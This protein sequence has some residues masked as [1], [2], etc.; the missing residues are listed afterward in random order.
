MSVNIT[1]LDLYQKKKKKKFHCVHIIRYGI[2][3]FFYFVVTI[4]IL[5][6]H[7]SEPNT[8]I[9]NK[10]L[11]NDLATGISFFLSVCLNSKET[12]LYWLSVILYCILK[13]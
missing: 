7:H 3:L 1:K 12:L 13:Y 8:E 6:F 2:S 11:S 4:H 5:W 10:M 9:D